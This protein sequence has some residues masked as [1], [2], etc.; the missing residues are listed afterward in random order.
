[1]APAFLAET[2]A[3]FAADP[4][5]DHAEAY[6]ALAEIN[7]SETRTA[8]RRLHDDT[9]HIGYRGSIVDALARTGATDNLEFFVSLLAG[10]STEWDDR[11]RTTAAHALG[12]IGGDA[13]AQALIGA[14]RS[15]NPWVRRSILLALGDTGSRLAVPALIELAELDPDRRSDACGPFRTLT[16]HGWC[17]DVYEPDFKVRWRR[18]WRRNG[19]RVRIHGPGER[20]P[21]D[22]DLPVVR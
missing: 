21:D 9:P 18:W 22:A 16:H 17:V 4:N 1:M 11:I 19:Q 8:L 3:K 13:A 14:P 20:V 7:T 5:R 12:C 2:T 10:R 15:P 6:R